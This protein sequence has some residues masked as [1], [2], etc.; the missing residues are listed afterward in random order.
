MML[1]EYQKDIDTARSKQKEYKGL[2]VKLKKRNGKQ[3]DSIIFELHEKV[4]SEIDCLKCANCCSSISPAIR[5]NDIQR[6]SRALKIKPS[7]LVDAYMWLDMDQDYVMNTKPCP[8]L[9]H[10]NYCSVYS[11]RPTACKEYPHTAQNHFK[12]RITL[13]LQNTLYCPAVARIF[14]CLLEDYSS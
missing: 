5:D 2:A 12:K 7:K 11:A 4:F 1:P 6:L 14:E 3:L 8:F 13:S 10:D 9:L